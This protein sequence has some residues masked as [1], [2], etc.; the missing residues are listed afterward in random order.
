MRAAERKWSIRPYEN[1]DEEGIF[2]LWK[3]VYPEHPYDREQW[4]RRWQW[5]YRANPSGVGV[6]CLAEHDGRIVG[7]AAEVPMTMK[8][9]SESVLASLGLDAMTHPD[10]RHQGMYAALVKAR[11][12]E[13]KARGILATY[14][15]PNAVS[16]IVGQKLEACEIAKMQKVVRPLN[17]WNALRIQT[18]NRALL[19]IGGVAGGLLDTLFFRSRKTPIPKGLTIAQVPCFDERID[20]LWEKVSDQYQIMVMRNKQYL[21]WRYVTAPDRDYLIYVAER[22]EAVVG[23]LVLSRKQVD[24]A[25]IGIIIDVFTE[26]EEVAERLI[27]E[28]VERCRQEKVDLLYGARMQSGSLAKAFRKNRFLSAPFLK[29]KRLMGYLHSPSIDSR[30]LQDQNNWFIQIGDSDEA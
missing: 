24:R 20:E 29:E 22:S 6:V 7:Q 13:S 5:M 9:G 12:A 26:S 14:S 25:E 27:S 10:Y 23:Y 30:F 2:A 1:G 21:D 18:K 17:W 8:I 28:A 15:F 19:T 4:M 11:R 3:A 16:Y